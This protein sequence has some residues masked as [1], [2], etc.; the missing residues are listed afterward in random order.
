MIYRFT[1]N[2]SP[3]IPLSISKGRSPRSYPRIQVH[4]QET[5]PGIAKR[6]AVLSDV[7]YV[8]RPTIPRLN[9]LLH[10]CMFVRCVLSRLSAQSPQ[11]RS[12]ERISGTSIPV[13]GP[14]WVSD[15]P[16]LDI[17][18]SAVF[19]T[20]FLTCENVA[21]IFFPLARKPTRVSC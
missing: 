8:Y 15:C 9:S 1:L 20:Y 19:L 2:K 6:A 16:A 17:F 7:E 12:K 14:F 21:F 13:L 3:S 4:G 11:S 10:T 5:L 18:K